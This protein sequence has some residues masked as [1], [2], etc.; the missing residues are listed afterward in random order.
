MDLNKLR[1]RAYNNAVL[2]GW[3]EKDY[4]ITWHEAA[5]K[6]HSA[7][8]TNFVDVDSTRKIINQYRNMEE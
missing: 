2:H 5:R 8:Y 6:L 4:Q 3:H 1:D 7:G